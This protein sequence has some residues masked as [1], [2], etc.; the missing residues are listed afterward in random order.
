[1]FE[2][3]TNRKQYNVQ[4]NLHTKNAFF[5]Q[6]WNCPPVLEDM[7]EEQHLY[8]LCYSRKTHFLTWTCGNILHEINTTEKPYGISAVSVQ[9]NVLR[10]VLKFVILIIIQVRKRFLNFK[11][12]F[13]WKE[14]L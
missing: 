1:M 8:S 12:L 9:R 10:C 13:C 7:L 11:T 4:C 6:F 14:L 2:T 5:K 3:F